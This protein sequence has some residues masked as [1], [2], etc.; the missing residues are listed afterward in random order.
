MACELDLSGPDLRANKNSRINVL[1]IG[2]N[3]SLE[4]ATVSTTDAAG[5]TVN[6]DVSG[7]I[8]ATKKKVFFDVPEGTNTVVLTFWPPPAPETLDIVED[9][10][11]GVTQPILRFGAGI[12]AGA[13]FEIIAG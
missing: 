13:N 6:T 3:Y 7:N 1:V 12:R 2:N 9:C 4:Q 5:N 11:T 10:G 8:D